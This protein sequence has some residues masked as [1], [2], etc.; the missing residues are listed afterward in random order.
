MEKIRT[1]LTNMES[2]ISKFQGF[3]GWMIGKCSISITTM[4]ENKENLPQALLLKK[5][6]RLAVIQVK[7]RNQEKKG[8]LKLT[9][10]KPCFLK[11][12]NESQTNK[13]G[14]PIRVLTFSQKQVNQFVAYVSDNNPIHK[15]EIA[16]VP[17]FMIVNEIVE[18]VQENIYK[19]IGEDFEIKVRFLLPMKVGDVAELWM[20]EQESDG[21]CIYGIVMDSEI[22]NMWIDKKN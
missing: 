9:L 11:S 17:G 8:M 7:D 21:F 14:I 10:I 2:A 18:L 15:K 19:K 3:D 20:E 1:L 22:F 6:D 13:R 16:I 5:N 12:V 4:K